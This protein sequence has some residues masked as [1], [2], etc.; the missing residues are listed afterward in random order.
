[1]SRGGNRAVAPFT[2]RRAG[3]G[4]AQDLARLHLRLQAHVEASSPLVWGMS[5]AR[6][7]SL[8]A[9]YVQSIKDPSAIVLMACGDEGRALG[10]ATGALLDHA[11]MR[12]GRS[13]TINSVWVEPQD[14]RRGICR[15]LVSG[16]LEAFKAGA[17]DDLH[18]RYAVGNAEAEA[19]WR[20]LGFAPVLVTAVARRDEVEARL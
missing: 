15:A 4:D 11:E 1:M 7:E 6:A 17:I 19:V 2:I 13:G 8:P 3:P 16:L 10:F 20:R 9:F 5:E 18:L 14:R 12:P